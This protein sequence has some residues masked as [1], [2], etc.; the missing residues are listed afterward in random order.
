MMSRLFDEITDAQRI[1]PLRRAI[2]FLYR[3]KFNWN[4]TY[5]STTTSGQQY[6]GTLVGRDGDAFMMRS[7]NRRILIGHTVD[8]DPTVKSGDRIALRATN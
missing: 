1:N 6:A 5:I 7:D 2:A 8:I 4:D 3:E